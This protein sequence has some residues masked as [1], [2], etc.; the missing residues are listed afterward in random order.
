MLWPAICTGQE[1]AHPGTSDSPSA[2][3]VF[4]AWY[5]QAFLGGACWGS[6]GAR[7]TRVYF[8]ALTVGNKEAYLFLFLHAYVKQ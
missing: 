2:L 5:E 8:C 7:K 6:G 4:T 3:V 1:A